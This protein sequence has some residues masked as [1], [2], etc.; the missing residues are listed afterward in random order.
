MADLQE[1]GMKT[2]LGNNNKTSAVEVRQAMD[3]ES[4]EG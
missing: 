2:K 3:R 4:E 1:F